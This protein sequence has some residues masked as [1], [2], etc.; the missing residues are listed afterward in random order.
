MTSFCNKV[1]ETVAVMQWIEASTT[2]V[3]WD[4]VKA[5]ATTI[6]KGDHGAAHSLW[7]SYRASIIGPLRANRLSTHYLLA[8]IVQ[9]MHQYEISDLNVDCQTGHLL[10]G[11]TNRFDTF[12]QFERY[13]VRVDRPGDL[14]KHCIVAVLSFLDGYNRG[15]GVGKSSSVVTLNWVGVAARPLGAVRV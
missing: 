10:V 11:L 6:I 9:P 15:P 14:V 2:S 3:Q 8:Q 5:G 7:Y 1:E 12:F 13:S 4:D